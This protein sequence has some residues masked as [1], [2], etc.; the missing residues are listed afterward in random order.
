MI[1]SPV[2]QRPDWLPESVWPFEIQAL[3]VH[4]T[5]VA[6]TDVGQ[7]PTMMFSHAGQWSFVWRDVITELSPQYRCVTF[8]PPGSG[9]SQRV[10]VP[11]LAI[12][13][14]TIGTLID[15]LDLRD[16][17]LVMHDLGGVTALAA[18]A[19]RPGRVAGLAAVNTFGWRP[20]G[21]LLRGM[22][23]LAGSSWMREVDA[24]TRLLPAA[25]TT[26]LGAGRNLDPPSRR[27]FR[28]GLDRDAV[29]AMHRLFASA[30]TSPE[31]F[32]D[33]ER[34]LQAELRRVP[35]LTV[36]GAWSDYFGFQQQWRQRFPDARQVRAGRYH[37]PMADNPKQFAAVIRSWHAERVARAE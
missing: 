31:V 22:L 19:D 32:R 27:A 26:R 6:Y 23:A 33:A 30:R 15:H 18:I 35:L 3:D 37:F 8:D 11:R 16:I 34:A 9:L 25:T 36:F 24:W 5:T 13:R 10:G 2:L 14:D 12:V 20:A 4:D 29:R 7:G 28:R 1:T 21:P 17:T